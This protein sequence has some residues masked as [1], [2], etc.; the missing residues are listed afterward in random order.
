MRHPAFILRCAGDVTILARGFL[1]IFYF[2]IYVFIVSCGHGLMR[3][4]SVRLLL[5]LHTY[6]NIAL[7]MLYM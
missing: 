2:I 4:H 3:V 7:Y 6:L 5:A 1:L